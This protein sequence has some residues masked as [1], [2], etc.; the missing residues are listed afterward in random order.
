MIRRPPRS[1][2]FPYTTLF[3]SSLIVRLMAKQVAI[4]PGVMESTVLVGRHLS[5]RERD[6]TV[7]IGGSYATH[8][9]DETLSSPIRV[10]ASLQYKGAKPDLVS[11][12]TALQHFVRREPIADCPSIATTY[13]TVEA[14]VGTEV[15]DLDQSSDQD[16]SAIQSYGIP[17]GH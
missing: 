2:L 4:C 7:G 10:F 16:P 1:T 12:R 15:R 14:V 17:L 5:Q 8:H 6:S 13:A 3:R 9:L 11:H